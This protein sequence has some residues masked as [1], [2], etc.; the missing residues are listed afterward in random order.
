MAESFSNK[1][2]RAIGIVTT[3]TGASVG[4]ST[5]LITGI[6]TAGVS[7][8]DLVENGNYIAGT[9]VSSIGAGQV[10]VD[11]D[12]TNGTSASNQV[13]KFM[14]PTV[15]YTSPGSVKSILIGGTFANN[16]NSQVGLTVLVLDQSTGIQVA[17]ASKVPVPAGSSFVISDTGKTLLEGND[18]IKVACDT[19]NAIDAN[20]SILTGVN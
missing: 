5:N 18:A 20:I 9:K 1:L 11:R 16:T 17:I 7:L 12:S 2:G 19:A 8:D 13:V 15:L 3:S 4:V 14:Q 6:S 10:V